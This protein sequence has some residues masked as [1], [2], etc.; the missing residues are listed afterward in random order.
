MVHFMCT[1]KPLIAAMHT[2]LSQTWWQGVPFVILA[3]LEACSPHCALFLS[4]MSYS[5]VS[6][7]LSHHLGQ[8]LSHMNTGSAIHFY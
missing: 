6:L 3:A 1:S 2:Y 4:L 8:S 7:S 5:D